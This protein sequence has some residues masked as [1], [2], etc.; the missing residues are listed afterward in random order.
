MALAGPEVHAAHCRSDAL[1]RETKA[2]IEPCRAVDAI[3]NNET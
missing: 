3:S 2:A 1:L